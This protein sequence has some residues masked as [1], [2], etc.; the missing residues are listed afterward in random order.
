MLGVK[1]VVTMSGTPGSDPD[2]LPL[3]GGEPLGR[4]QMDVLDYLWS[5]AVEF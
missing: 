3:V 4:R 2:A 5:I 1:N